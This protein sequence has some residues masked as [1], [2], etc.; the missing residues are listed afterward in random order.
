MILRELA[1]EHCTGF[2]VLADVSRASE[3]S[4]SKYLDSV[5]VTYADLLA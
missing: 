4:R 3:E 5:P 2:V 1:W